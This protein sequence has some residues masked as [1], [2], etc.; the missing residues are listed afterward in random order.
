[1]E[2]VSTAP[3]PVVPVTITER[4]GTVQI[5]VRAP[6]S[7]STRTLLVHNEDKNKMVVKLSEPGA[8]EECPLTLQ[9]MKQDELSF[10]P[11]VTYSEKC[12]HLKKMTLPCK[13]SFGAMTLVYH[14][15]SNKVQCPLCREGY[16]ARL[17]TRSIPVHFRRQI[18]EKI[19][20]SNKVQAEEEVRVNEE[21]ARV[22]FNQLVRSIDAYTDRIYC[23]ICVMMGDDISE[24][25]DFKMVLFARMISTAD[26]SAGGANDGQHQDNLYFSL[27]PSDRRIMMSFFREMDIQS[28]FVRIHYKT[29]GGMMLE[30]SHSQ[31]IQ[32]RFEERVNDIA[33]SYGQISSTP[34][35]RAGDSNFCSLTWAVESRTFAELVM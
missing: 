18:L 28:F 23:T 14:F 17:D 9:P 26:V 19:R 1:M 25:V 2:I 5:R 30:I 16:D 3:A 12:T 11:N 10:L 13:H 33:C 22:L 24:I 32:T 15:A 27:N 29:I 31:P 7:V 34:F 21:A 20:E 8:E 35:R 4:P 6:I